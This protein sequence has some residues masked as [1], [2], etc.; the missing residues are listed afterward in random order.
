MSKCIVF[1]FPIICLFLVPQVYAQVSCDS[2][3]LQN[4]GFED[5]LSYWDSCTIY[6][7]CFSTST[8]NPHSGSKCAT[9]AFWHGGGYYDAQL[10]SQSAHLD[11]GTT[12]EYSMWIRERDTRCTGDPNASIFDI[13]LNTGGWIYAFD[14]GHGSNPLWTRFKK[15]FTAATTCEA[16]I[17][18]QVHGYALT[19]TAYLYVDDVSFCEY[20]TKCGDVTCDN[21]VSASD[22][23]Y[24]VNYLFRGGPPPCE[25]CT[26]EP[27][28]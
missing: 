19:D 9:Y 14:H 20:R 27:G 24:L 23:V 4:P 2:N 21:V 8:N 18:I 16:Q 1:M 13:E 22:L 11:S 26:P 15:V 28:E 17:S 7:H 5:D 25:V 12:Y 6:S 10:L 3:F